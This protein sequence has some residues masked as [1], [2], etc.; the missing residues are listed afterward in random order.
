MAAANL[1]KMGCAN[2]VQIWALHQSAFPFSSRNLT[3]MEIQDWT[4]TSSVQSST[5][6]GMRYPW[7]CGQDSSLT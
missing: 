3:W 7:W 5:R 1:A 6:I 4:L 2:Y